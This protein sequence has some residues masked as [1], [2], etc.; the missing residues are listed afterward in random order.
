[1]NESFSKWT[2]NASSSGAAQPRPAP[3]VQTALTGYVS[4]RDLVQKLA[5]RVAANS[6]ANILENE[7]KYI[8]QTAGLLRTKVI[9][10]ISKGLTSFIS[11]GSMKIGSDD[12]E[13]TMNFSSWATR[14]DSSTTV[15]V[16]PSDRMAKIA[17]TRAQ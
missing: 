8:P 14:S 5:N 1:M 3:Q 4:M 13:S 7:Y 16:N 9:F 11:P 12:A 6:K 2:H 15:T 17:L 10:R